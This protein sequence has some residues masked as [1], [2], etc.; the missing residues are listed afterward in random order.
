MRAT[1]YA[2]EA[3]CM[4]SRTGR[5]VG[6]P[7][8][9][10]KSKLMET[11]DRLD[12]KMPIILSNSEVLFNEFIYLMSKEASAPDILSNPNNAMVN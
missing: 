6:T 5:L 11:A 3:A 12:L 1:I 4:S 8:E 7:L 2:I 10:I 9:N